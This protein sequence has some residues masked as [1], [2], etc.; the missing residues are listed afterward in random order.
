MDNQLIH[1]FYD[2]SLTS[3]RYLEILRG[4]VTQFFEDFNGMNAV[5]IGFKYME[6]RHI[7]PT[8]SW[9][10]PPRSRDLTPL[11]PL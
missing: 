5:I 2:G 8:G 7:G 4:T 10:W 9:P 3:L 11:D 1:I 6:L